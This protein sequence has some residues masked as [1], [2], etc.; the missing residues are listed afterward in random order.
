MELNALKGEIMGNNTTVVIC[1]DALH[2][3]E[4]DPDFCKNL[5][6]ALMKHHLVALL[7]SL[8]AENTVIMDTL[9]KL[10]S[11]IMLTMFHWLLLG[12]SWKNVSKDVQL[13]RNGREGFEGVAGY[14]SKAAWL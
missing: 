1:N 11:G 14:G 2:A 3:I 5:A 10:L 12:P 9:L 13:F 8:Q 4:T 6:I 7:T